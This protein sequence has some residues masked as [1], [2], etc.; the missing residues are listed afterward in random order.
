MKLVLLFLSSLV[1][2]LCVGE[3]VELT[4]PTVNGND[5]AAE[6]AYGNGVSVYDINIDGWSDL[7]ICRH[8]FPM[9]IF[10]QQ[11]KCV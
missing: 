4:V 9:G 6:T 3:S 8:G 1:S 10:A 7:T 5:F 2:A 11:R